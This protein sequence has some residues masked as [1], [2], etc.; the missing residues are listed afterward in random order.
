MAAEEAYVVGYLDQRP[1]QGRA[2]VVGTGAMT[3]ELLKL[4]CKAVVLSPDS[5][6]RER[7]TDVAYKLHR[8]LRI[9]H[10]NITVSPHKP[11]NYFVRFD[12]P[13]QRAAALITGSIFVGTT[14]FVIHPWR[15]DSGT[16]P[17]SWFFHAKI[18]VEG[19]PLHAWSADG[20]R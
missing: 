3:A 11:E 7:A 5:T 14:S 15:L 9:P 8:Q 13:E 12:Y 19:L 6:S 4:H 2:V 20:I 1:S 10:W 17:A 18:C 16:Q